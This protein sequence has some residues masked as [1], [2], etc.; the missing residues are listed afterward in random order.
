MLDARHLKAEDLQGLD[1]AAACRIATLLLE[2]VAAIDAEHCKQITERDDQIKFKDAKLQKLTFELAR[3]KRLKFGV[4]TEAM[5]GDQRCLFEETLAE[6]EANLQ[7]R[8][9]ALRGD[10]S[11]HRPWVRGVQSASRAASRFLNTYGAS[12][13]TTSRRTLTA[14]RPAAVARWCASART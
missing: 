8:I 9:D 2:R 4:R 7:A 10:K 14:Q 5:T 1:A 11:P 3:L 12:I 13:T 6:D